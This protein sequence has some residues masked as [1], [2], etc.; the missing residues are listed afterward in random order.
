MGNKKVY[1]FFVVDKLMKPLLSCLSLLFGS[2]LY[3]QKDSLNGIWICRSIVAN[4]SFIAEG[5]MEILPS[6]ATLMERS[7]KLITTH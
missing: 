7:K 1:M 6:M 4:P 3:S 2:H 5:K